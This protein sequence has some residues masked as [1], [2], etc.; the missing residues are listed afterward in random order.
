MG[1]C[2]AHREY[3]RGELVASAE[4][5]CAAVVVDHG[6]EGIV[7]GVQDIGKGGRDEGRRQ[8]YMGRVKGDVVD[9][10]IWEGR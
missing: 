3:V 9:E 6:V 8:N 5:A 7:E 4:L 2:T 10:L 1:T